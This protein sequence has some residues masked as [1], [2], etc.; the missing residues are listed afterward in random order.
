VRFFEEGTVADP[1]PRV[2]GAS[3]DPWAR[4]VLERQFGPDPERQRAG[5][6]ANESFRRTRDHVLQNAALAEGKTLLDVG[7]GSGLIAFGALP[8]VGETGAVLFS[9]V[10]QQLLDHCRALAAEQGVLERCRFLLAPADDLSALADASVDAVTMRSVL[11]F[12]DDKARAFAGFHRV[13][14]RGGRLS[15]FEPI[16]RFAR[17]NDPRRF[18]GHDVG[19]FGELAARVRRVFESLQPPDSDAMMNFDER[20]LLRL[21]EEAGFAEAHLQYSA[22]FGVH[23]PRSWDDVAHVP[24]NPRIPSL[25]EILT[26]TLTAEERDR[27]VAHF[28]PLVEAGGGTYRRAV[29]F[30]WAA[31]P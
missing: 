30:L 20:D 26:Q 28:R 23:G 12:V 5:F 25:D 24:G 4:W 13:L 7:C 27:L 29:A 22:E 2:V 3:T 9:D 17:A 21:A 14:R 6:S 1:A 19:P 31:K 10:S 16:N 8:L 15:L 11:I 18:L